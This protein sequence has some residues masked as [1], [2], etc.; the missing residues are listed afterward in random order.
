MNIFQFFVVFLLGAQ[1]PVE[2]AALKKHPAFPAPAIEVQR[3][4]HLDRLQNP[5]EGERESRINNGV[6][7]VEEEDPRRQKES[8]LLPAFAQH[9]R[10]KGEFVFGQFLPRGEYS[11]AQE[12]EPVR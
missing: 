7:V 12:A 1:G 3:C 9:P 6:P 8:M 2:E 11:A 5:R 10:Q 4:T